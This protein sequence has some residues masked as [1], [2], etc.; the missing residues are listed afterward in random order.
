VL[1]DYGSVWAQ[2]EEFSWREYILMDG[3]SVSQA[4]FVK[5]LNW[6]IFEYEPRSTRPLSHLFEI[7]D[8]KFRV[9]LWNLFTPHPSLSLTWVFLLVLTPLLFYKLLCNVEVQPRL[10]CAIT[11]LYVGNPATL[12]LLVVDFRPAKPIA[13]F[14]I[15]CSLYWASR[16]HRARNDR[17]DPPNDSFYGLCAFMLTS[18]LFDETAVLSFPA[19]L[20]LFPGIVFRNVARGVAFFALPVLTYFAWFWWI[21]LLTIQAGFDAPRLATYGPVAA[22]TSRSAVQGLLLNP[23]VLRDL[24]TNATL[25]L[26]DLFG[27]VDPGLSRSRE[28]T[29]LWAGGVLCIGVVILLVGVAI[30]RS[31]GRFLLRRDLWQSLLALLAVT[32]FANL[33]LHLVENRLWG[34]HWLNTF[35]P[36]FSLLF[37]GVVLKP[38][39]LH[40]LFLAA[41]ASVIVTASVYNF[42][43]VN[44]GFKSFFYYRSVSFVDV[45]T[46]KVNRFELAR[47]DGD[48]LLERTRAIWRGHADATRLQAI[49][50][51]LYYLVHDLRLIEPGITHAREGTIFDGS[52]ATFDLARQTAREDD[53]FVVSPSQWARRIGN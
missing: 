40:P 53:Y 11:A 49:P 21:P 41:A 38:V 37:L 51:E 1:T 13:S 30:V 18:F 20:L 23:D 52:V 44:N 46:H 25:F 35:W 8:T 17:F 45:L 6:R 12:S 2:P 3:T 27:L 10:A 50:T 34:L 29:L 9:A 32:F 48:G 7:V 47:A 39:D 4:D 31:R 24:P 36:I 28:Y 43:Y 33:T 22:A 26:S 16:I 14:A 15:V 5:P 19:V 42:T